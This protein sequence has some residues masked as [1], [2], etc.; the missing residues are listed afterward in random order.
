LE[1]WNAQGTAKVVVKTESE[2]EM[3]DIKHKF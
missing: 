1:S 2:K 3:L